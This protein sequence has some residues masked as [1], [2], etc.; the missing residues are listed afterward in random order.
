MVTQV[1]LSQEMREEL[2]SNCSEM[3][4]FVNWLDSLDRRPGLDELA[5]KLS[6]LRPNSTALEKCVG[7]AKDG[8][9]R[10]IVKKNDHYELVTI[11]WKPGQKTPIH[12]HVG[13]DCA[14]L[15]ISGISTET[16]YEINQN[17][18]VFP[19]NSIIRKSGEVCAAEEQ[20]IHTVSNDGDSGLVELHVYTPPLGEY[21]VYSSI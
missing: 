2:L 20:D 11:C 4:N 14:F 12:D 16:I 19:T 15:I 9:Q 7:Y 8:Y 5:I 13:S 3:D 10:H 18:L 6:N 1:V 21:N 17:G